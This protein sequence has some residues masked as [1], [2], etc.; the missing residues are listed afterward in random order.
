VAAAWPVW[1]ERLI[2]LAFFGAGIV[3][4]LVGGLLPAAVQ[5]ALWAGL[6]LTLALVSAGGW[7]PLLGPVL[8]YDMIR[9]T[10]R[11][12]YAL[13]RVVYALA[14]LLFILAL[15]RAQ[16]ALLRGAWPPVN[17]NMARFAETFCYT[18]LAVQFAAV[19]ALT[20][21]Y[22]AGAVAEEKDRKTLE[23]LLATDLRDR[24]IVLGK[25]TSRVANLTLLLL[26]GLPILALTQLW[27]GVDF[28]L[29]LAAFADTGATLLSLAALGM[30]ASVHCRKAREAVVLTYLAAAGYAG[31]SVLVYLL[32]SFPR[33][34]ALPLTT[35]TTPYQVGDL[36]DAFTGGNPGLLCLGIRDDL[37]AGITLPASVSART[38][39]YLAFHLLVTVVCTG[40]AVLRLRPLA[41]AD[42]PVQARTKK[43]G[44]RWRF[45]WRP[46]LGR[47]ALLWKE[48]W[49]EPGMTFNWFG[50]A[51]LL[52]IV[53]V[54]FVPAAWLGGA[55]LVRY[56]E[57]G[58]WFWQDLAASV[59]TWV[60]VVGTLVACLTLLGVAVRAAS[61]I[62][63]ERDRQTFDSLL[64][65]PVESN[66][67]LFAKWVGSL[68][69][70]RRAWLW[71]SL[72]W[73][74]GIVTGGLNEPAVPWLLLSWF[75]YAGFLASLG[76]WFSM[77]CRTTLRATVWTLLTTAALGVGHWYLWLLFCMPLQLR[78]DL[79]AW[80]VRFQMYG[81]T[82]PLA[83]G[84][85][86]FGRDSIPSGI[87]GNSSSSADDP[88]GALYC[89]LGGLALWGTSGYVLYSLAARRFAVL[90]GRVPIPVPVVGRLSDLPQLENVPEPAPSTA[91]P[92]RR[93]RVLLGALGGVVLL[94]VGWGVFKAVMADRHLNAALEEADH[95]D[96]GWRFG[97]ILAAREAIPDNQNSGA[98]V[99]ATAGLFPFWGGTE[100]P[101]TLDAI[102]PETRLSIDQWRDLTDGLEGAEGALLELGPLADLP[103][104][105]YPVTWS[106]DYIGTLV[107]H[108]DAMRVV[109]WVIW[110]DLML[111]AEEND[112][113]GALVVCRRLLNLGR[114]V[115]DEPL[116][117]TQ[118]V[119]LDNARAATRG[120]QRVLAQGE[121]SEA[122]LADLQRRLAEEE[123]HPGLLI[124]TRGDRAGLD[125][126][127][128]GIQ[129]GEFPWQDVARW[130][131][132]R[133]K[134]LGGFDTLRFSLTPGAEKESRAALLRYNTELVKAARLPP[135]QQ[136]PAFER[137][138]AK[139]TKL[140]LL[141]RPLLM[142]VTKVSE[143][144]RSGWAELRCAVAALAAERFRQRHN[145]W[146]ERL[147]ELVPDFL[148]KVPT[149]PFGGGPL[150]YKRLADGVVIYSAGPDG[151]DDGGDV[152]GA[153][154]TSLTGKD[155]G[156]RL[157]D[158]TRRRQGP[159]ASGASGVSFRRRVAQL[160]ENVAGQAGV[161]DVFGQLLHRGEAEVGHLLLADLQ[162]AGYVAVL[163]PLHPQQF[164][165]LQPQKVALLLPLA[166]HPPQ[167]AHDG[168]ALQR[169]PLVAAHQ[170]R[171]RR[172][173]V[174]LLRQRVAAVR[175]GLQR[176]PPLAPQVVGQLVRGDGEQIRLQLA[177]VVEVGQAVEEA[178][179]G[180]LHHVLA[181][182][183][184]AQPA[185]HEGQK[186][187]LVAADKRFPGARV[188]L[189]DFLDQQP[190][191]V[192]RH[193]GGPWDEGLLL[194]IR[195]RAQ[196]EQSACV[197]ESRGRARRR[198][199]TFSCLTHHS[200]RLGVLNKDRV[201]A[202]NGRLNLGGCR[203]RMHKY[204]NDGVAARNSSG[205][206]LERLSHFVCIVEGRRR[207][208]PARP[209]LPRE[210]GLPVRYLLAVFLPPA[211]VYLCR[212]PGQLPV[213]VLLTACLWVPGVVHALLLARAAAVR[214]R[215]D[216]VADAVLAREERL[217]RAYRRHAAARV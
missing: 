11:G 171:R 164:Q 168:G 139:Q 148:D 7:L 32:R 189:A 121:P 58:H 152:R 142:P 162:E 23:F 109:R 167:A 29:L 81:L 181:G 22:V 72:V 87:I 30:V 56:F 46:R 194:I 85:L 52:L 213:S 170:A 80:V 63:G 115:G 55:F 183:A 191:V 107:R 14:L 200:L 40:W 33:V 15:H 187:A 97:D 24:E 35:G 118:H 127:M 88:M 93:R 210:G 18:F 151:Q 123:A 4:W 205:R 138:D 202:N 48:V 182:G 76:L 41:L 147:A 57:H 43:A 44:R 166:H 6:L 207:R 12:R 144:F 66:S 169:A 25:M 177:F 190:V 10:R 53:L 179:E 54:S 2:G 26:T 134:G 13:L 172:V 102:P 17:F 71:L 174:Q 159:R 100:F 83:L 135:E 145:R 198:E 217:S 104:G 75:V 16:P 133:P 180:F 119:R 197:R 125:G 178:D 196:V 137:L 68:L 214:E 128:T 110:Y 153:P 216:R 117:S 19:I 101:P 74:L 86:A 192:G 36:V 136:G 64:T 204:S 114:S 92:R 186:P 201:V 99:M 126:Y 143:R 158:V 60:R 203:D 42:G 95:T 34:A 132:P 209:F 215:A 45:G 130:G 131:G 84:W 212:R 122:A 82:P 67:I 28:G 94:P 106:R 173:M 120:A 108:V 5:V 156:F 105:R 161:A 62:S 47:R 31:L 59:N 140:P 163:P 73:L 185:V 211:A 206:A 112:S 3:L 129:S 96:P 9:T 165:H 1:R 193:D 49:A 150:L 155:L 98:V 21:A 146:P 116:I 149:D 38:G 39:A 50:K 176:V 175:G 90:T 69:S 184:V 124:G 160:G 65:A 113:D 27:G 77:T 199:H 157:W 51:V 195:R 70:V 61:S 78:E 20:P 79:F 111:R 37:R 188:A 141:V 89:L 8:A 154:D 91:R 103:D 208:R